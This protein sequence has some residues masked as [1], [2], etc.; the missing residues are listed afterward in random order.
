MAEVF[1]HHLLSIKM[2]YA[3]RIMGSD[4]YTIIY[5]YLKSKKKNVAKLLVY[6][7]M[8]LG[9]QSIKYPKLLAVASKIDMCPALWKHFD[10]LIDK[11]NVPE[12]HLIILEY[13]H[14]K[15]MQLC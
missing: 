4:L 14:Y 11:L 3:K 8:R 6:K 9:I 13:W 2:M 12:K 10:T 5:P 1:Q 15:L 7:L